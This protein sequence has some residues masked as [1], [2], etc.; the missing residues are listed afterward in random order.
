MG[1]RWRSFHGV[2][3]CDDGD[4]GVVPGVVAGDADQDGDADEQNDDGER[5]AL[6][7]VVAAGEPELAEGAGLDDAGEVVDSA[8]RQA[9]ENAD[10]G[11]PRKM[12]PPPEPQSVGAKPGDREQQTGE[13]RDQGAGPRLRRD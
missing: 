10:R 3:G 11:V 6:R 8:D 13:H 7:A 4:V 12:D 5:C 9:E 2:A 1:G